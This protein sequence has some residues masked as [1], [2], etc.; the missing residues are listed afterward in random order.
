MIDPSIGKVSTVD[1]N[2]L[3]W[4]FKFNH[5]RNPFFAVRVKGSAKYQSK[6]GS[7]YDCRPALDEGPGQSNAA[8][9]QLIGER[10]GSLAPTGGE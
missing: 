3:P 6:R 2:H 1:P 7:G 9:R 5:N 8:G 10:F 4:H